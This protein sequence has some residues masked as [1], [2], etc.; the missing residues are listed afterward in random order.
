M[1]YFLLFVF[2]IS[3]L[4]VTTFSIISNVLYYVNLLNLPP[5]PLPHLTVYFSYRLFL[6]LYVVLFRLLRTVW[7]LR[8]RLIEKFISALLQ[9][10]KGIIYVLPCH[11]CLCSGEY[12]WHSIALYCVSPRK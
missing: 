8:F 11:F 4:F 12:T 10:T 7:F 2:F 6:F 3:I 1:H 5:F 9:M